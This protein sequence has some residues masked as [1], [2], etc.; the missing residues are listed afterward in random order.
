M[1]VGAYA[2]T[3]ARTHTGEKLIYGDPFPGARAGLSCSFRSCFRMRAR[4]ELLDRVKALSERHSIS[5]VARG[6]RHLFINTARRRVRVALRARENAPS[7]ARGD[8]REVDAQQHIDTTLP[9]L[10]HQSPDPRV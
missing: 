9:T 6:P 8:A 5:P 2:R 7:I 10:P 4:L 1:S 3:H